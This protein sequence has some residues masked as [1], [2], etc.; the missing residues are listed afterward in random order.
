MIESL[1]NPTDPS[2]QTL[3]R[4][5]IMANI[6][7][8]APGPADYK[9]GA[10]SPPSVSSLGTYGES[11]ADCDIYGDERIMSRQPIGNDEWAAAWRTTDWPNYWDG[12]A[13]HH[14]QTSVPDFFKLGYNWVMSQC[15]FDIFK[16]FGCLEYCQIVEFDPIVGAECLDGIDC[17]YVHVKDQIPAVDTIASQDLEQS[18]LSKRLDT[19]TRHVSKS[20]DFQAPQIAIKKS[21]VGNRHC[22]HDEA[23][24]DG[25]LFVSDELRD[26]WIAAGCGPIYFRQCELVAAEYHHSEQYHF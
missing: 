8:E 22:W 23:F 2:A 14:G 15:A 5:S 25:A 20:A 13:E 18:D 1:P 11:D 6:V 3:E 21:V 26:A 12:W 4:K 7:S 19:A 24:M 9:G 16:S 17:W 10:A